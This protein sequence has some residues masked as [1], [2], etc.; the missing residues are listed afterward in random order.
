MAF[1]LCPLLPY[2]LSTLP[3]PKMKSQCA[4]KGRTGGRSSASV[5]LTKTRLGLFSVLRE[6]FHIRSPLV[7][8][9]KAMNAARV[10]C[11]SLLWKMI[12]VRSTHGC[13]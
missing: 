6:W 7:D 13:L 4:K 8:L 3:T 2:T 10:I 11:R 12:P 1:S 5:A 9:D